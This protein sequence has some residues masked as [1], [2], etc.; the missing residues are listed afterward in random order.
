M[1][2]FLDWIGSWI[3][4]LAQATTSTAAQGVEAAGVHIS[5][6]VHV[7][8]A[9]ALIQSLILLGAVTDMAAFSS[10]PYF[11]ACANSIVFG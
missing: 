3:D 1:Q 7:A 6:P 11:H 2:E 8:S 10:L 4:S 5:L 9:L